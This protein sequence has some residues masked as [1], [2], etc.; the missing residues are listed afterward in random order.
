MYKNMKMYINC[1][2]KNYA[3]VRYKEKYCKIR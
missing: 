1:T 2:D 3:R